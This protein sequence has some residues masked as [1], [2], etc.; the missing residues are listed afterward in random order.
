MSYGQNG[1]CN[2]YIKNERRFEKK[3]K[4]HRLEAK[5][6]D[7]F[8]REILIIIPIHTVSSLPTKRRNSQM[9]VEKNRAVEGIQ[10][11]VQFRNFNRRSTNIHE[12]KKH[13]LLKLLALC[14]S[15]FL[16]LLAAS[17]Y[18]GNT[19]MESTPHPLFSSFFCDAQASSS[20]STL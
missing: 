16:Q 1:T 20:P 4:E 5:K 10:Q 11:V 12:I 3:S 17:C 7:L 18:A 14:A 13:A 2:V 19:P 9:S 6:Y 8:V 15:N